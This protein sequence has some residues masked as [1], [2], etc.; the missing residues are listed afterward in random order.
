MKCVECNQDL[1]IVNSMITS[2]IDTTDVLMTQSFGCANQKC[3]LF[4]GNDPDNRKHIVTGNST[5]IN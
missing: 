4:M 5:V 1:Y 2:D 3:G